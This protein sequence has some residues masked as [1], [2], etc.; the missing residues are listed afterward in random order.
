[1]HGSSVSSALITCAMVAKQGVSP[2]RDGFAKRRLGAGVVPGKQL[3]SGSNEFSCFLVYSF[4]L[5]GNCGRYRISSLLI[6][7]YFG[8]I[9]L[10]HNE[11]SLYCPGQRPSWMSVRTA[12][13]DS[14][15]CDSIYFCHLK[16]ID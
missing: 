14:V 9:S 11:I 1:M 2:M 16:Q 6:Y 5:R 3:Q 13:V 10:E 12:V 7:S 15:T 4:L 8:T